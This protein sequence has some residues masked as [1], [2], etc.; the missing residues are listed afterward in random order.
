MST[1]EQKGHKIFDL[2][3][4]NLEYIE[5]LL[6]E[7][8]AGY[9]YNFMSEVPIENMTEEEINILEVANSTYINYFVNAP[10]NYTEQEIDKI[11]NTFSHYE[12]H[13]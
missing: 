3:T 4:G 8:E 5:T 10:L 13:I 6:A 1:K 2:V 9:R 11:E 12:N 7:I